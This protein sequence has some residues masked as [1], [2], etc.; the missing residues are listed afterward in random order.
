M[1]SP[2]RNNLS[3][4]VNSQLHESQEGVGD[5]KTSFPRVFRGSK[6]L[7]P[8]EFQVWKN[9]TSQQNVSFAKCKMVL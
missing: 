6:V 8:E 9:I 3:A 5:K 1:F 7:L 4:I 2:K